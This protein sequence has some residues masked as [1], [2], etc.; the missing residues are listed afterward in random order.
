MYK[1]N[2]MFELNGKKYQVK[3]IYDY[4]TTGCYA[5]SAYPDKCTVF[6]ECSKDKREDD[7]DVI[8]VE[9][10]DDLQAPQALQAIKEADFV[11][12]GT[13]YSEDYE[14]EI[15]TVKITGKADQLMPLFNWLKES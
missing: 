5:C 10:S 4:S 12:F 14:C 11:S 3:Q 1:I 6:P 9:V 8:F 13:K 15:S 7:Q 2:E